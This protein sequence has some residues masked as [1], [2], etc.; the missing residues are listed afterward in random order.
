MTTPSTDPKEERVLVFAPTGR[1]AAL[2]RRILSRAGIACSI[3]KNIEE[4]CREA[5]AGAGAALL[6]EEALSAH[7]I[8]CLADLL[9]NQP[10]WSD[11]PLILFAT[12]GESAGMLLKGTGSWANVSILERPINIAIIISALQSAIRS[13]R[14]QYQMRDLLLHMEEAD[15]QKDLF[16]ATLS[17]ELRTPLNSMLGWLSLIRQK[18]LNTDETARALE[19]IDRNARTQAQMIADILEVSRIITGKLRLNFRPTDLASMIETAIE[20]VRMAADAKGIRIETRLDPNAGSILADGNRLQQVM[21]NLLINAIKFTPQSGNIEVSLRRA[22]STVQIEVSD[23]GE[24]ID[25]EVL[26]YIFDRFRQAD[27]S[28]KRV[29]GGLGLGLAIVRHIVELHGGRVYA[30]SKGAGQGAIFSVSLPVPTVFKPRD[31]EEFNSELASQASRGESP[32]VEGV[33]VLLVED[34]PDSR[35]MVVRVLE[36]FGMQ[37]SAVA[38]A[39]EALDIIKQLKPDVL[40]SDI[41]M[42]EEDGYALLHKVRE[43]EGDGGH[44]IPAIALSGYASRNDEED[45]LTAGFHMHLAKPVEIN[46]LVKAIARLAGRAA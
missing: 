29:H 30:E 31:I 15:R 37:V 17:H 6:T 27:N 7:A 42:P 9:S 2:T 16:L 18:R 10:A 32:P 25:P 36:D 19:T 11:L 38:S 8:K 39:S 22:G 43:L 4:L 5:S 13:R 3:C 1:D 33:R 12:N 23:T 40:V 28:Y 20:T 24:G 44:S 14:R 34:D 46:R 35:E 21:W 45:A 41:G 26:P